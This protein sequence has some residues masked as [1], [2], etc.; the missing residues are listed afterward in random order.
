MGAALM[1]E[2]HPPGEL[3]LAAAIDRP[4]SARVGQPV[5]ILGPGLPASLLIS[6][7]LPAALKKV[8]VVIDFSSAQAAADTVMACR[9][10]RVP[11]LLGTTGLDASVEPLLQEAATQIPVL[12]AANTSIGVNVLLE[13]VRRAAAA[14]PAS[15]DIEIVETHHRHKVDA[16]SGTAL[17]LGLAASEGRGE[18]PEPPRLSGA[19][20]G[21]RPVGGVGYG[22]LRGGDVAGEHEVRFLGLGE[23]L[24]L[25]H[26]ATDRA[27]FAR[28]AVAAAAWLVR[29]PAGRYRMVDFL[30]G[31]Q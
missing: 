14:L 3:S 31:N 13:L 20:P 25:G 1:R 17:A 27:V 28:G 5:T 15:F 23:S 18:S 21:P 2:L 8:D 24:R 7:D 10:A 26:Q 16:P 30:Y 19:Q 22:V 6:S 12:T 11:L 29:Q 9:T 4:G